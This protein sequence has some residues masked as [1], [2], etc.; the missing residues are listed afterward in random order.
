MVMKI[1]TLLTKWQIKKFIAQDTYK[2]LYT[3]DRKLPRAYGLIK[4]H[5]EE[6]KIL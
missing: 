6:I 4:V 3:S 1:R 2:R 5:K